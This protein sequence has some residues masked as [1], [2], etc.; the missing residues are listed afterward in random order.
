M[1]RVYLAL[2]KEMLEPTIALCSHNT[3]LDMKSLAS[4]SSYTPQSQRAAAVLLAALGDNA[5]GELFNSFQDKMYRFETVMSHFRM[6]GFMLLGVLVLG[7]HQLACRGRWTESRERAP[8]LK[9]SRFSRRSTTWLLARS[10]SS[11]L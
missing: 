9:M 7:P 1:K 8:D 6:A 3:C 2:E 5:P 11:S 4:Q 10:L